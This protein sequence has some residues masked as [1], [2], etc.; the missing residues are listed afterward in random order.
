MPQLSLLTVKVTGCGGKALR[1][2]SNILAGTATE[3]SSSASSDARF[4]VGS[5]DGEFFVFYFEKEIF[6]NGQYRIGANGARCDL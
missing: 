1:V 2:S 5:A 4:E 6:Q 3:K